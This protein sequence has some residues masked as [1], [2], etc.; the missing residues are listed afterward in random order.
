MVSHG[1]K[2]VQDFVHPQY[3][4]ARG[5]RN[6]APDMPGAGERVHEAG[7]RVYPKVGTWEPNTA[8]FLAK[9][10]CSAPKH[11][12]CLEQAVESEFM[13]TQNLK[14]PSLVRVPGFRGSEAFCASL[15]MGP[16]MLCDFPFSVL[17]KH[18]RTGA[19]SK[20]KREEENTI[21]PEIRFGVLLLPPLAHGL[22]A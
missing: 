16:A 18:H 12:F 2:V 20:K 7:L 17:F 6:G 8:R 10:P 22:I 9:V 4:P 3:Q 21:A 13:G 1:F 19:P 14:P 15:Q 5:W 11:R